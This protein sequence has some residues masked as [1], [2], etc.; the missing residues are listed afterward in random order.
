M[1]IYEPPVTDVSKP[2]K[3]LYQK[4]SPTV[5]VWENAVDMKTDKHKGGSTTICVFKYLKG[6]NNNCI[7]VVPKC[8]YVRKTKAQSIQP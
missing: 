2:K 4:C 8:S 7:G 6:Q 3:Q 5:T 1:Y